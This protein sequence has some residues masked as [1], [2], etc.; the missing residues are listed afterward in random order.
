MI[1]KAK[2]ATDGLTKGEYYDAIEDN[3][4]LEMYKIVL[5]DNRTVAFRPKCIFDIVEE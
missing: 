2:C 5:D 1:V 3:K 4:W